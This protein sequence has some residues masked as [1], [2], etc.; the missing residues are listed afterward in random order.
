MLLGLH[1]P[2]VHDGRAIVETLSQSAMPRTLRTHQF[3]L[4]VL[5]QVYK[6]LNAPF[7]VFSRDLLTASTNALA[8]GTQ[9]NDATYTRLEAGIT[10]L[11]N[12]RD[13]LAGEI[14]T[15]LDTT[16]FAGASFDE[17]QAAKLSEQS[18][19]LLVRASLLAHRS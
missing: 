13:A 14:K 3:S 10:D 2:Y 9:A 12:A 16:S 18:L 19:A 17:R 8:S 11:T 5:T 4:F 7:G 15:F 6:Q 1:D